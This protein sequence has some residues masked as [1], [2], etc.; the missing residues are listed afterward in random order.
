[1]RAP[2]AS[3]RVLVRQQQ[4][5]M[6]REDTFDN[7]RSCAVYWFCKVNNHPIEYKYTNSGKGETRTETFLQLSPIGKIPVLK[8]GKF[9]LTE[10]CEGVSQS[11]R[12]PLMLHQTH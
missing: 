4:C 12:G 3:P 11:M 9:V 2:S 5:V 1:M 7:S 8:D 6:T 10:R